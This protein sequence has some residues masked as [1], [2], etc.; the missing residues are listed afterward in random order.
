[1]SA[2]THFEMS[3]LGGDTLTA[4]TMH[5]TRWLIPFRVP[6]TSTASRI[7]TN[8]PLPYINCEDAFQCRNH[9]I[10]FDVD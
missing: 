6:D 4:L 3:R 9:R 5:G 10:A 7:D 1:M 2:L 8:L